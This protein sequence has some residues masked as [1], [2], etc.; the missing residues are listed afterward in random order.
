[1]YCTVLASKCFLELYAYYPLCHNAH[2]PWTVYVYV[3][4]DTRTRL[5]DLVKASDWSTDYILRWMCTS[6]KVQRVRN[7]HMARE[8]RAWLRNTRTQLMCLFELRGACVYSTSTVQFYSRPADHKRLSVTINLENTS[9]LQ[10]GARECERCAI[11]SGA[12]L[13]AMPKYKCEWY[14]G[15]TCLYECLYE[16]GHWQWSGT[17]LI[18]V[19]TILCR[20][21]TWE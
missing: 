7:A 1:M 15:V 18:R 2:G 13:S 21:V 11:E 17:C 20:A 16:V 14:G 3:R 12:K 9:K 5:L 4:A 8:G 19:K 6:V 10:V